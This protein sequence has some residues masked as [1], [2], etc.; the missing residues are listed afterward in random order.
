ML[1]LYVAKFQ[2][3]FTAMTKYFLNYYFILF[4][5]LVMEE[6]RKKGKFSKIKKYQKNKISTE[7][8]HNYAI[9]NREPAIEIEITTEKDFKLLTNGKT[10]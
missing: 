9:T 8:D 2:I 7:H 5:I 3:P 1:H 10:E 4:Q 6:P